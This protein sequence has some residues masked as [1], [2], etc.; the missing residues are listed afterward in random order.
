MVPKHFGQATVASRAP[1]WSQRV[2]SVEAGAPHI[3]QF[4]VSAGMVVQISPFTIPNPSLRPLHFSSEFV[5]SRFA[6]RGDDLGG[7][8]NRKARY[9]L[10]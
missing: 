8:D 1:Q 10:D 7:Q 5:L 3:G 2:A 9:E 4:S 6:P